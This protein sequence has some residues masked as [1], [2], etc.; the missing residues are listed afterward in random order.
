MR[1]I[2]LAVLAIC[3]ACTAYAMKVEVHGNL[4]FATGP[5]EDDLI[6]FREAFANTGV[7]TVAFVN[8][9]GGDLWTGLTIGRMIA[10]TGLKTVAAGSCV[11]ACSIMFMGGKERSFSDAFRPA[12]TFV[13]IHGAH[14]KDTKAVNPQLQPQIFAFYKQNM[15]AGFNADIMNKALYDM[16]DA[17]AL[18]RVF[19]ASR[20]P[21]RV[22]FHCKSRQSPRKDC[23]EFKDQD[24]LSLGIVTTNTLTPLNL[25]AGFD[26][27]PAVLGLELTYALADPGAYFKEQSELRCSTDA[28]RKLIADFA[29]TKEHKAFAV[30]AGE[31]G[32]GIA[33]NRDTSML[34][35]LGAIYF[36]NHPRDK[37]ARLCKAQVVDGYDVRHFYAAALVSH[38]Q[39]LAKLSPPSDRFYANEEFGG[40][41]T[42]ASGL[43]TQKM[44]DMTPQKIDGVKTYATQELAVA[45]KSS[46]PPVLVDVWAGANVAIPTALTVLRGGLAFEDAAADKAFEVRFGGLLKLLSPDPA[47]PVVFYCQSRDC[48]L[49]VNASMR[50]R[51]LGYTQ[52][53]WY[54]GGMDSWRAANLPT[55]GIV[56]E[57]VAH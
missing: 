55:A 40:G 13:G 25:P 28:C 1:R 29:A 20:P 16:E 6:K 10:A 27:V 49:A 41:A 47:Q 35:F 8:S 56:L 34:A 32:W 52:V 18:L 22:P 5:V 2:L 26:Q 24:A 33:S 30:A 44:Q 12:Q 42:S 38:E 36:C 57:A 31:P 7:D 15:S 51:Q 39:A 23:S 45:L 11:S 37:P 9:P 48:W 53:G 21:K 14:N 3:L 50:A 54:R 4:V 17:G 46:R 43:R 19:D